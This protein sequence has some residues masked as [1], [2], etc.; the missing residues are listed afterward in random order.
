MFL[1][2]GLI[3]FNI[4]KNNIH[5]HF[6]FCLLFQVLAAY[7]NG[8]AANAIWSPASIDSSILSASPLD[9]RG[10]SS[11][12]QQAAAAAAAVA[13]STGNC[14]QN[15]PGYYPNVDYLSSSV[16]QQLVITYIRKTFI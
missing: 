1:I 12:W 10:N 15:Y 3:L 4:N 13:S 9:A 5:V 2:I 14:Y 16:Q 11:S 8:N 7:A 6:N